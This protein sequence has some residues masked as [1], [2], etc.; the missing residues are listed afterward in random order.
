MHIVNT[1]STCA[2]PN[3]KAIYLIEIY[4]EYHSHE[5]SNDNPVICVIC[6]DRNLVIG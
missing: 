6:R 1:V 2:V 4:P 5:L 3:T